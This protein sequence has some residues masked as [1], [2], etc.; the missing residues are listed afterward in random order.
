M[1]GHEAALFVILNDSEESYT[2][3]RYTPNSYRI[4]F[5]RGYRAYKILRS[6]QNDKI[7]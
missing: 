3:D 5:K 7:N 4:P 1:I 6:A 2:E